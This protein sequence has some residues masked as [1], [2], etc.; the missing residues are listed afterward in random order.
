M[1]KRRPLS[2]NDLEQ[3]R[4]GA[5]WALKQDEL[6]TR[7]AAQT[8]ESFARSEWITL[9][10]AYA[11]GLREFGLWTQQLWAESLGTLAERTTALPTLDVNGMW[12]GYQGEGTKTVL[13]SQASFKATLRLVID[14]QPFPA[15]AGYRVGLA[16]ESY[17]PQVIDLDQL[18]WSA[19]VA[20][21]PQPS[22]YGLI[23]IEPLGTMLMV[24]LELPLVLRMINRLLGGNGQA[25]G[26]RTELTE[27]EA[28]VAAAADGAVW[29]CA[30]CAP[31]SS[32]SASGIKI[33]RIL[34]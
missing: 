3:I 4:E 28:A 2:A 34:R 17:A 30:P 29:A 6:I 14:P 32:A 13:P 23:E 11:D 24:G 1:P 25:K 7:L 22:L 8:L 27:I 26:V 16:G 12:G 9:F 18:S 10:W 20:R 31:V 33:A 5:L 21:V 19:A 15:L